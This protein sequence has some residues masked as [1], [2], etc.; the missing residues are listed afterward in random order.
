M[1]LSTKYMPGTVQ[2]TILGSLKPTKPSE[3]GTAVI[4]IL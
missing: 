3:E 1:F 4:L 2:S